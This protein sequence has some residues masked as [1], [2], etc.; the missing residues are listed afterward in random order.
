MCCEPLSKGLSAIHR[1]VRRDCVQSGFDLLEVC[2]GEMDAGHLLEAPEHGRLSQIICY[3]LRQLMAVPNHRQ[4]PVVTPAT[5]H[6]A[7]ATPQ[8]LIWG[9]AA[10][11]Q[12]LLDGVI[13]VANGPGPSARR[14]VTV[15]Q[16]SRTDR[17]SHA[18]RPPHL[19][20][21]VGRQYGVCKTRRTTPALGAERPGGPVQ[22]ARRRGLVLLVAAAFTATAAALYARRYGRGAPL[23]A[24]LPT[25]GPACYHAD[26]VCT[27]HTYSFHPPYAAVKSV[28]L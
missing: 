5:H 13:M 24:T 18:A 12:L 14:V 20:P 15:S 22:L 6:A 23:N 9:C 11:K 8:C 7:H 26:V 1:I 28:P 17:A 2:D 16:G 4:N 19:L 3:P 25:L 27:C 10:G 21:F